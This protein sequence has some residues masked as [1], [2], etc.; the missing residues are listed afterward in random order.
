MKRKLQ[1]LS[2]FLAMIALVFLYGCQKENTTK[3]GVP[4]LSVEKNAV[5]ALNTID[6]LN[7]FASSGFNVNTL[8]ALDLTLG[9]C[10]VISINLT[11]Q[12]FTIALDWGSGCKNTD[13][14]TRSGK[15]IITLNGMMNV[16]GSEATFKFVDFVSDGR[17]ISGVHKFTFKGLNAVNNWPRYAA[18]SE[19]KIV[20]PDQSY[21]TY[22]A[23]TFHLQSAGTTTATPLDDTWR[24]E[25][26]AT[27]VGKDKIAWN[28]TT[29][30]VLIKK[31]DCN[32]ISSGTIAIT[33]VPG[34]MRTLDFGNETCD[35][36]ATLTLDGKTTTITL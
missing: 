29:T 12:P 4:D 25:G 26:S 36:K 27:G 9:N 24:T 2:T 6:E 13:G 33:P 8:K 1:Y 20:Y 15:I 28:A 30:K 18:L 23:E 10:P 14:I 31:G 21:I 3:E 17:K 11:Q 7:L 16:A 32:Y 5:T 34:T 35:D 22:R 19:I